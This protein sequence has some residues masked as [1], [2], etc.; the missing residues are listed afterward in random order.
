MLEAFHQHPV[1]IAAQ[2]GQH[3]VYI[4]VLF[5]LEFTHQ[6]QAFVA[7]QQHF[8]RTGLAVAP[9]V[10]ARNVDVHIVVG[11]L[12][13]G[14]T[15]A[16]RA[17]RG[18]Q[19]L[20]QGGLAHARESGKA[21]SFHRVFFLPNKNGAW[22]PSAVGVPQLHRLFKSIAA[23]ACSILLCKYFVVQSKFY[24]AQAALFFIKPA[25]PQSQCCWI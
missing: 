15:L 17:Q 19:L 13:R 10:F 7:H 20:Q 9:A 12:D 23:S 4:E 11:M 18:N 5:L 21:Q 3:G 14:H 22:L 16:P 25:S 24:Q 2:L 8:R 6:R 1:N